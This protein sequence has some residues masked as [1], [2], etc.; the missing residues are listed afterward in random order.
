[1]D[2]I[3]WILFTVVIFSFLRYLVSSNSLRMSVIKQRKLERENK[4]DFEVPYS[5]T[6]S[7][8]FKP[9][10]KGENIR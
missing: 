1:M 5:D 6:P 10:F 2:R 3:W 8:V 9:L 7:V 4:R